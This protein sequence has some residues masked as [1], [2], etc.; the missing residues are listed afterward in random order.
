VRSKGV[1]VEEMCDEAASSTSS[2][3]A[4]R[5]AHRHTPCVEHSLELAAS[6]TVPHL[7]GTGCTV[8]PSYV[9]MLALGAPYSALAEMESRMLSVRI[10]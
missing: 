3:L 6:S 9:P 1:T 7:G 4:E 2:R 10:R 5:L 8:A